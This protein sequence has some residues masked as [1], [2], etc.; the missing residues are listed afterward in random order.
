V[1]PSHYQLHIPLSL[2]TLLLLF[3]LYS[4]RFNV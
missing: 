1:I 3:V 4:G 2:S